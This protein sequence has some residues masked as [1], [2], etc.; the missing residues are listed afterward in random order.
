MQ[1]GK[2]QIVHPAVLKRNTLVDA[3]VTDSIRFKKV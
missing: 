3:S 1:F 2:K